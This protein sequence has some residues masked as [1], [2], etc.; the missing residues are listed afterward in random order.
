MSAP[1][2]VYVAVARYEDILKLGFS[3]DPCDRVRAFHE[4]YFEYFDLERGLCLETTAEKDA[5]RIEL[6]LAHRLADHRACA[7]LVIDTAA[8]GFTEWYRGAYPQLIGAIA[9]L[10]RDE[11]YASPQSLAARFRQRL[12]QERELLFERSLAMV[13]AIEAL[14]GEAQAER[15]RTRLRALLDAYAALQIDVEDFL[16]PDVRDWLR[17]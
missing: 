16:A 15:L 6:L 17:R 1:A 5:R 10:V 13:D 7:P 9:Q 3:H 4:R 8:G 11:G 2:F 12:L 14:A